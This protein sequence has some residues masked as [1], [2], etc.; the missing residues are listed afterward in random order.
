MINPSVT[1]IVAPIASMKLALPSKD[2]WRHCT[3][4]MLDLKIARG[5]IPV[6]YIL[7]YRL[8]I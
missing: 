4:L 2:W 3:E 6:L 7:L 5:N 8:T 1:G